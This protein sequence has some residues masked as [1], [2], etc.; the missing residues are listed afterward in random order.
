MHDNDANIV[1]SFISCY[2]HVLKVFYLTFA[3]VKKLYS[4]LEK[5]ERKCAFF[6][7][8]ELDVLRKQ[9]I[10]MNPEFPKMQTNESNSQ[11]PTD[12]KLSTSMI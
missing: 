4:R 5:L 12:S 7:T 1:Y 8:N 9:L 2:S 10:L 11:S 6:E 3:L